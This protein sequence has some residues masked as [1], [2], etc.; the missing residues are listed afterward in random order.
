[1]FN[2]LTFKLLR[3]ELFRYIVPLYWETSICSAVKTV[4]TGG[5]QCSYCPPTIYIQLTWNPPSTLSS[6]PFFCYL[7]TQWLLIPTNTW[8]NTTLIEIIV[9]QQETHGRHLSPEQ[10][11]LK[12][13]RFII[14]ISI[15]RMVIRKVHYKY[16]NIQNGHNFQANFIF[17]VK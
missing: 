11:C 8:K 2:T 6:V 13:K 16:F 7:E 3:T 14:I 15:Y 1:M 12:I 17:L 5:H 10:Q 9:I 4:S